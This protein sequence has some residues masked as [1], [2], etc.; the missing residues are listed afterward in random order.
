M[1]ADHW[2]EAVLRRA[3]AVL[4][5]I[6]ADVCINSLRRAFWIII[7]ARC[8][9]ESRLPTLHH[10]GYFLFWLARPPE[11][12]DHGKHHWLGWWLC[13]AKGRLA[14]CQNRAKCGRGK[15]Q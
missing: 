6:L 5:V 3:L 8:D 15:T 13:S 9:D 14:G 2:P 7:I 4:A 1:V 10:V 11:I 12:A